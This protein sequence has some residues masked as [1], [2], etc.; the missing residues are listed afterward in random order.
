MRYNFFFKR[1]IKN[2]VKT[3][4]VGTSGHQQH[5][6]NM[7]KGDSMAMCQPR[8][9]MIKLAQDMEEEADSSHSWNCLRTTHHLS[10]YQHRQK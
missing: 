9:M 1:M 2:T 4:I 7:Q 6:M 5:N 10:G 3:L 8:F